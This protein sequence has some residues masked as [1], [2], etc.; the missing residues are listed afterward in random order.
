MQMHASCAARDGD[1]VLLLGASG[2]GKSDLVLRLIDIGFCLV[3]DDRVDITDGF[4]SP[5]ASLAG[6]LEVR[7]LGILRVAHL[8]QARLRLAVALAQPARLPEPRRVREVL[9]ALPA[10]LSLPLVEIDPAAPSAARKVALALDC[11][12]GRQSVVAGLVPAGGAR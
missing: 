7:G 1:G 10:D 5:P 6:L 3:A 12:L 9:P 8:P 2:S 11:V 4:A